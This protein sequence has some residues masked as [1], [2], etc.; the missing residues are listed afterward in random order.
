MMKSPLLPSWDPLVE[1]VIRYKLQSK[2]ERAQSSCA[3]CHQEESLGNDGILFPTRCLEEAFEEVLK[4]KNENCPKIV[5]RSMVCL[6][7]IAKNYGDRPTSVIS[8]I[9]CKY[10]R[11]FILEATLVP[12]YETEELK[13]ALVEGTED[14]VGSLQIKALANGWVGPIQRIMSGNTIPTDATQY[15]ETPELIEERIDVLK[16]HGALEEASR[17]EAAKTNLLLR[18]FQTEMDL[19]LMESILESAQFEHFQELLRFIQANKSERKL[20]NLFL[21]VARAFVS[22][23]PSKF[24]IDIALADFFG[25]QSE[26]I[27]EFVLDHGA[28]EDFL[29]LCKIAAKDLFDGRQ[30]NRQIVMPVCRKLMESGK[31]K[32]TAIEHLIPRLLSCFPLSSLGILIDFG[33]EENV[34]NALKVLKMKLE[35]DNWVAEDGGKKMRALK[36]ANDHLVQKH[37]SL[38]GEFLEIL[39]PA[40]DATASSQYLDFILRT[41]NQLA[42]MQKV[43]DIFTLKTAFNDAQWAGKMELN[44]MLEKFISSLR[45]EEILLPLLP[46]TVTLLAD[47]FE[48]NPIKFVDLFFKYCG[49]PEIET[50]AHSLSRL[51]A[52]NSTA[53]AQVVLHRFLVQGIKCCPLAKVVILKA[54]PEFFKKGDITLDSVKLLLS[55]DTCKG[56]SSGNTLIRCLAAFHLGLRSK[57][58][59]FLKT[60]DLC[61][62]LFDLAL[63]H[64]PLSTPIS[65]FFRNIL[66]LTL[67][68]I[69]VLQQKEATQRFSRDFSSTIVTCRDRNPCMGCFELNGF[70]KADVREKNL[71]Y[72]GTIRR[73]ILRTLTTYVMDSSVNRQRSVKDILQLETKE[74]TAS[75]NQARFKSRYCGAIVV[76]KLDV[77]MVNKPLQE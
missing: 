63:N 23:Y 10:W 4:S 37:P 17:F 69:D 41:A 50:S 38:R 51:V 68:S 5:L 3:S 24:V 11:R 9:I 45:N 14:V 8:G 52:A 16:N 43:L 32:D 25:S 20:R 59:Q 46:N 27:S 22:K 53:D 54:L 55:G 21:R 35:C 12:I 71:T 48:Q 65:A 40:F 31:T 67:Q 39:V 7:K 72:N 13:Q 70:L 1:V 62:Y 73:C 15:Q 2:S 61:E 29:Q 57:N 74:I 6:S 42:D 28:P 75:E 60:I 58:F 30:I 49:K 56:D 33:T 76:K 77:K 18:Q 36:V 47:L 64:R 34:R 19:S 26:A 66:S 44:Q